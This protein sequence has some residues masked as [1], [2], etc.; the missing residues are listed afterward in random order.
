MSTLADTFLDDLDDL[1]DSDDDDLETEQTAD[2]AAGE[3]DDSSDAAA[4][5]G[6]APMEQDETE[7][8]L[9]ALGK[10]HVSLVAKVRKSDN[11]LSH[12][13][14]LQDAIANS[15]SS[16]SS[17]S[18]QA[19]QKAAPGG[20]IEQDPEY[21]LIVRSNELIA[22]IDDELA[23]VHR[24][25]VD[26]YSPKFP[27]LESI[28]TAPLEYVRTVLLIK[29]E[30]D[31]TRLPLET[32]LPQTTVMVVSVTGS[33]TPG[34]PLSDEALSRALEGCEEFLGLCE[35]KGA[36]LSFVEGRMSVIAPNVCAIIG[37][38]IAAQLMGLAGG[39]V[40]MSRIPSCN[41]QRLSNQSQGT[42]R[43]LN[44]S[45]ACRAV[46]YSAKASRS[47]ALHIGLIIHSDVCQS[48]PPYLRMRALK[49]A[50][51]KVT[52]AARCDVHGT[53]GNAATG[54]KF[55]AELEA[56]IEKWQEP[57]KA[58][59]KKALPKPDEVKKSR[60]GGKRV[61]RFKE[62]FAMTDVRKEQN[63]M[64]FAGESYE[65]GDSAMGRDFGMLGKAGGKMRAPAQKEQKQTV[66]KKMRVA[67][68]SSGTTNGMSSSLVFTPIQGLELVNPNADKEQKVKA[69]NAKW[70]DSS[71]GFMSAR[72]K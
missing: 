47:I 12:M 6:A 32:I 53:D 59:I 63:K 15:S 34:K 69:A 55:R 50:A 36:L 40:S 57:D 33:T 42:P 18:E 45:I 71:S 72:P 66:T 31:M 65:Y 20:N 9:R 14:S 17:S 27:E 48:A 61:R 39:L 44:V 2:A 52:L 26:T 68:L 11:F 4:H 21:Q 3:A 8:A 25:V 7:K 13:Q 64:S 70:F 19:E 1:G 54:L 60:R 46:G 28:V 10:R 56:K 23:Q 35:A 38:R 58:K 67:N 37:S 49:V 30:T 5:N 43:R 29:N 41:L 51:A 16:S 22:A 62:K 24:F